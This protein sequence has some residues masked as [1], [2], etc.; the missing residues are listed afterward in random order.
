QVVAL[1]RDRKLR[2]R[3]GVGPSTWPNSWSAELAPHRPAGPGPEAMSTDSKIR[4]ALEATE[5]HPLLQAI[6]CD[7]GDHS[8]LREDL[9]PSASNQPQ[10]G[11]SAGQLAEARALAGAA[12]ERLVTSPAAGR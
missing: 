5:I 11:L 3:T 12:L 9:R 4:E 2:M 6:A 10:G 8:L 7:T 1:R